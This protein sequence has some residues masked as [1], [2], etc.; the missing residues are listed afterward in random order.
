VLDIAAAPPSGSIV[1]GQGAP[2]PPATDPAAFYPPTD[3]AQAD[4]WSF[5]LQGPYDGFAYSLLD[6][7][8]DA[9]GLA[10]DFSTSEL[11]RD[12]CALQPKTFQAKPS[13]F[14]C[15]PG[16]RHGQQSQ[17]GADVVRGQSLPR[18]RSTAQPLRM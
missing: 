10:A 3:P 9:T 17:R 16:R 13:G 1:F 6:V 7:R 14:A 2:P 12:W 15:A 18:C 4:R 8:L 5:P 11:W